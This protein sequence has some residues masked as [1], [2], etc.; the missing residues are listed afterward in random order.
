MPTALI[1]NGE[2]TQLRIAAE[3][4]ARDGFETLSCLGAEEAIARLGERGKVEL[5]DTDLYMPGIDGW[6]F[7]RL[8]RSS[9]CSPICCTTLSKRR[10]TAARSA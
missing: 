8:L 4:L 9:A 1:V 5:I 3:I 2:L 6:G 10:P 7:C